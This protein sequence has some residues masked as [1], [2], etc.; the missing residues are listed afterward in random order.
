[1]MISNEKSSFKTR[2]IAS[3]LIIIGIIGIVMA[4]AVKMS[5][6]ANARLAERSANV[7]FKVYCETTSG[8]VTFDGVVGEAYM[9]AGQT[10]IKKL[11][12][13]AYFT[14]IAGQCKITPLV[15]I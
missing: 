8:K 15:K 2:A 5:L 9:N 10:T 4:L 1:M 12:G 6:N 7:D 3:G 13:D 11:D 14:S